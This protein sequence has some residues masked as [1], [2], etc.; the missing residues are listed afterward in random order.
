M[1]ESQSTY[2]MTVYPDPSAERRAVKQLD[3]L[4]KPNNNNSKL[5]AV[6]MIN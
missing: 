2:L 4:A 5:A 1:A 6:V 3:H